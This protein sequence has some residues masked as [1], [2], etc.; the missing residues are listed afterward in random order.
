MN[1]AAIIKQLEKA[2]WVLRGIKGSHHIY[3]HPQKS[4]HITVP[5]PKKDLGTGLAHKLLK[6]AGLK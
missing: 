5:H 1:S 6:Q 4:G 3:T 2:G